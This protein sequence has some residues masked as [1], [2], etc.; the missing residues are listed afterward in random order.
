MR[1][2]L[3]LWLLL[4]LPLTAIAQPPRLLFDQGHRQAFVIDQAGPLHLGNLARVMDAEGWAISISSGELT[5]ETL[6][7]ID[8]LI[9]SGA[10]QPLNP[11]EINAIETFL[12]NGGRLAIMLHIY[13]PL[14][15]LLQRLGVE[16]GD[17]VIQE[18]QNRFDEQ[19][20]DFFVSNFKPHPLTKGLQQFAI[21]GG[22][23]L[24]SLNT[25]AEE[26]A[27]CSPQAWVD[28]DNDQNLSDQDLVRPFAVLISGSFG[29]GAFAVF[30]DDAIF[31]NKFLTGGNLDL[32]MNLARW[33]MGEPESL[34]GL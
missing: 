14:V 24:Q 27:H 23:P 22:W 9:I 18:R 7:G 31:Q 25:Q 11:Q 10:F 20:V 8:A 33:L 21:Y 32:A 5:S 19:P 2:I 34:A 17:R 13:Q 30:A 29:K 12:Q 28:S 4:S 6:Q 26:I 1:M 16:V 15:P 3:S